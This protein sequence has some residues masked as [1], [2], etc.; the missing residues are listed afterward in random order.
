MP[1]R[2]GELRSA[3]APP[4]TKQARNGATSSLT[5]VQTCGQEGPEVPKRW[6]A[7]A[8]IAWPERVSGAAKTRKGLACCMACLRRPNVRAKLP[9]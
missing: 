1:V 3:A 7:E 4:L 5:G 6:Q 2:S 9:A 8:R